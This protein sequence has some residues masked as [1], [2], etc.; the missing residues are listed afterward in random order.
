MITGKEAHHNV[1]VMRHAVSDEVVVFDGTGKEYAGVIRRIDPRS[2]IVG[3]TGIRH[4]PAAGPS[5][6]PGAAAEGRR[7]IARAGLEMLQGE[8][9]EYLV[10]RPAASTRP[11]RGPWG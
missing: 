9:V 7:E 3:I 2:V 5:G 10:R 11:L 4:P 6:M 8:F 1:D